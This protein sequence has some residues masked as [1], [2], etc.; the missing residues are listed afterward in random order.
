MPKISYLIPCYFNELNIPITSVKLIENESLFSQDVTFEYVLVDDGSKDNTWQELEKFK[1]KYPE[2]VKII[3]LASNVGSFN[4]L[5]AAANYATGD[6]CVVLAADLQDPPELIPKMY[7]YWQKG[8]KLVIA[9]RQDRQESWSQ[10]LF[11]NTFHYF[12]KNFALPNVPSGGFDLVLFDKQLQHEIVKIDE[13]NSNFL[14]LLTWL[15]FD[16][17]SIPY[18]RL[19]R[20]VGK[21][22]WTLKKKIKMF[23]DSFVAFSFFPLRMISVSGIFLGLI[24]LLYGFFIIISKAIGWENSTGWSSLM[25]VLLFVSSFQMIALGIIGEYVWRGLDASRKRPN[26]IVDKKIL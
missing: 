3:K 7:D 1:E 20:E 14:Y 16:Y 10:K 13:K 17:V 2:K 23:I 19:K 21:S 15:G 18:T 26:F 6:C 11:S 25:V 9:N 12:M 4:A 5:L 24:A 22:R 8:V